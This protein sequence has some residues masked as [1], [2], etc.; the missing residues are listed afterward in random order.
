VLADHPLGLAGR[1]GGVEHVKRARRAHRDRRRVRIPRTACELPGLVDGE[2]AGR[3][4]EAREERA[5]GDHQRQLRVGDDRLDVTLRVLRI[6]RH[7]DTAGLEHAEKRDDHLGS[8][9]AADPDQGPGL[10]TGGPESPRQ[11][12]GAGVELAVGQR[13]A[14]VDHRH[15]FGRARHLRLEEVVHTALLVRLPP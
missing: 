15:R 10:D 14:P 8:A 7:V 4:G 13:A 11:V 2:P 3:T 5:L 9:R 12:R 1:A 6:E